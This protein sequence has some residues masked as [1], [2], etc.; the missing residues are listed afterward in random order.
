MIR[1]VLDA[2][3]FISAFIKP[4]GLQYQLLTLARSGRYQLILSPPILS[5][6]FRALDY[7]RIQKYLK[8][9]KK[10]IG[11][12]MDNLVQVS[13]VVEGKLEIEV[14]KEDPDDNQYLTAAVEGQA[15]YIVSRDKHLLDLE[16]YQGIQIIMARKFLEYLEK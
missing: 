3:Q 9:T 2:N 10:D 14:I 16:V 12:L 7:S 15:N 11:G 6:I 4:G 13:E 8:Y 1:A 5:E